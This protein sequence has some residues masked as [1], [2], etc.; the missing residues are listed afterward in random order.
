[1][2]KSAHD[3]KERSTLQVLE[4][5]L[6]H[7][8]LIVKKTL[9]DRKT[10]DTIL[11]KNSLI[12]TK[13]VSISPIPTPYPDPPSY[14]LRFHLINDSIISIKEHNITADQLVSRY[15]KHI[16]V[17]RH[18]LTKINAFFHNEHDGKDHSIEDLNE[19]KDLL[20]PFIE[21]LLKK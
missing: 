2:E 1:M 19:L 18:M 10:F 21:T 8:D 4:M 9:F 20:I 7:Q 14:Q 17:A 3:K 5:M 15:F 16:L 6:S 12:S 11:D 13:K